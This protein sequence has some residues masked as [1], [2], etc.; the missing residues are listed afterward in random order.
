MSQQHSSL[1]L[2]DETLHLAVRYLDT[3]L[4]RRGAS[5]PPG[6]HAVS[7]S[8]F[9]LK[10]EMFLLRCASP[11][12][13]TGQAATERPHA[14][15][16]HPPTRSSAGTES[17]LMRNGAGSEPVPAEPLLPLESDRAMFLSGPRR[18]VPTALQQA[19]A[20]GHHLH[21]RGGEGDGSVRPFGVRVRGRRGGVHFHP[22]AA[23]PRRARCCRGA[24]VLPYHPTTSSFASAYLSEMSDS[25]EKSSA[26]S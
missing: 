3:F 24:G 1:D 4:V 7:K 16:P 10:T 17:F 15:P 13:T 21:L 26:M 14:S 11:P 6:A 12:T 23:P 20:T 25:F 22:L 18:V 2:V 19:Q 5:R 9:K 8:A